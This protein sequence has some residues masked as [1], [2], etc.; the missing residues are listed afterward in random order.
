MQYAFVSRAVAYVSCLSTMSLLMTSMAIAAINVGKTHTQF[1][2]FPTS[3][4]VSG[5]VVANTEQF[6]ALADHSQ[7]E[8][9][10]ARFWSAEI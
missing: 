1:A 4:S 9:L 8:V 2:S 10:A 6:G 3:A 5:I 7:I